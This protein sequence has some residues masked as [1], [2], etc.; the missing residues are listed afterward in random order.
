VNPP[1]TSIVAC[2]TILLLVGGAATATGAQEKT[3]RAKFKKPI[4][5][6]GFNNE[7]MRVTPFRL[8]EVDGGDFDPPAAGHRYVGV[9]VKLKNVGRTRYSDSPMNSAKLITG[10]GKTIETKILVEGECDS[11][12]AATTDIARGKT[13]RGC[14]PFEVPNGTKLKFFEFTLASGFADE[15]G[16]WRKLPRP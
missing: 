14:I 6:A 7:R 8:R 9:W 15:T 10:G 2:L 13:R 11:G 5:L 12:W 1:K 3:K 16:Q 4:A